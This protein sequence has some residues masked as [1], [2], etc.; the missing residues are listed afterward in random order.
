MFDFIS[1]GEKMNL[2]SIPVQNQTIQFHRVDD[3]GLLI[4]TDIG[5]IK[6]LNQTAA[7]IWET[8]DGTKT[9]A[10]IAKDV[11]AKFNSQLS[12]IQNDLIEFLTQLKNRSLIYLKER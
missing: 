11:D 6:G 2:Q 3:E 9:I 8:I 7:F 1:I 10:E 12:S 4:L 5:K